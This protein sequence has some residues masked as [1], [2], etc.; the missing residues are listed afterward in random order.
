LPLFPGEDFV[1]CSF[2]PRK[3][4]HDPLAVPVP[5]YHR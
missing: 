5:Y 3:I 1:I 4:D 2:V